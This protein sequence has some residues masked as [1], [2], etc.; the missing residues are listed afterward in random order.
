[1]KWADKT[2]EKPAHVSRSWVTTTRLRLWSN[3][4]IVIYTVVTRSTRNFE[5]SLS[6]DSLTTLV[7]T[8]SPSTSWTSGKLMI[9]WFCK[10]N[11]LLNRVDSALS[12]TQTFAVSIWSW[13]SRTSTSFKANGLTWKVRYQF[14]RWK[15]WWLNSNQS[16][17]LGNR[18]DQNNAIITH[19]ASLTVFRM[20]S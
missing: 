13:N 20:N 4:E 9:A 2:Q 11:V 6:A 12:L 16:S 17:R 19:I 14:S 3:W 1:M 18:K 8:C 7:T 10:T 15:K 5:R